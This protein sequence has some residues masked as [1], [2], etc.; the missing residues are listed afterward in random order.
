MSSCLKQSHTSMC[1]VCTSAHRAGQ[2]RTVGT[3]GT[4]GTGSLEPRDKLTPVA[5]LHSLCHESPQFPDGCFS[6]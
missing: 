2:G 3:K 1:C 5:P 4:P 6:Y